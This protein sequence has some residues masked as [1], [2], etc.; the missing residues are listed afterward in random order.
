MHNLPGARKFT[1]RMA[2]EVTIDN[3]VSE[4][5]T[6]ID[7]FSPDRVGLL[8]TITHTLFE[9]GFIIHLARIS[10]TADQALDVFYITDPAG[11]KIEDLEQLRL[12]K[13]ALTERLEPS[14]ESQAANAAS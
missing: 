5:C 10:T 3:R 13:A 1:R 12:L 11:H 14:S 4:N 2:T 8:F 6:V 7:V 9:L